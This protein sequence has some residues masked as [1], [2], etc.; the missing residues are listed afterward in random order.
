MSLNRSS[1]SRA[2]LQ[3]HVSQADGR[4]FL[5]E[6]QALGLFAGALATEIVAIAAATRSPGVLSLNRPS[7]DLA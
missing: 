5:L 2:A 7:S 6:V 4:L 1:S 3:V